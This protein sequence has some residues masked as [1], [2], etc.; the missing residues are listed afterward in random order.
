MSLVMSDDSFFESSIANQRDQ[1]TLL[2]P[3]FHTIQS[4]SKKVFVPPI[5][6]PV[7]RPRLRH[8]ELGS[9]FGPR[10]EVGDVCC[11][12]ARPEAER[13]P[14]AASASRGVLSPDPAAVWAAPVPPH[15]PEGRGG[16]AGPAGSDAGGGR[17]RVRG[18][19]SSSGS[20]RLPALAAWR[21]EEERE[22]ESR[23]A[24]RPEPGVKKVN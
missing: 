14:A 21:P 4:S 2:L 13:D 17:A 20:G 11:P 12:D 23:Q 1:S 18:S 24:L 8:V 15:L 6:E 5:T 3:S 19:V 22:P 16:A 10:G 7:L 9:T